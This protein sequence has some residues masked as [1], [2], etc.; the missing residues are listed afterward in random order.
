MASV[1]L[2]RPLTRIRWEIALLLGFGILINYFDRVALSVSQPSLKA[3]FGIGPAEFGLLSAT[4]FWV[5][6]LCQIP[7][8]IV[9]DRFGVVLIGRIGAFFWGIAAVMSGIAPSFGFLNFARGFLGIAEAPAFPANAKATSYWF[10]NA[11]RGLA[12]SIFD[13]AAKF[14][15]VIA[16]PVIALVVHYYGWR[17][18]FFFTAG[19]SFIYFIIYYFF[20]RNPSQHKRVSPSEYQYI[21]QG[22]A[23]PE[24]LAS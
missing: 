20:Y 9:L 4:F 2:P 13:A 21:V 3:E 17:Q 11:E 12:T 15:N 5:Y 22:G 1:A 16:V 18:A 10:P 23:Q 24:G 19:L 6:A 8:G 7:I 14:S